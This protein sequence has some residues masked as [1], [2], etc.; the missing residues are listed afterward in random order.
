VIYIY[1]IVFSVL[2]PV[3]LQQQN[4]SHKHSILQYYQ[5]STSQ[6]MKLAS[7]YLNSIVIRNY[8]CS[9]WLIYSRLQPKV[10]SNKKLSYCWE[11]ERRESMPRIGEMDV[12][13]TAYTE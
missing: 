8:A 7:C 11:T 3:E 2:M 12:E 6:I 10:S 9:C 13:M 5:V 4:I 1:A